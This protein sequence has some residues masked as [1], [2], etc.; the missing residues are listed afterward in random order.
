MS[1]KTGKMLKEL[2]KERGVTL[3]TVADAIG[4]SPSYLHR[5]ENNDRKNPSFT[6]MT[7]LADYYKVDMSELTELSQGQMTDLMT[8][9]EIHEEINRAVAQMKEGLDLHKRND[10]H[11]IQKFIE[12]Q[13]SLLYVQSLI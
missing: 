12:V 8:S 4:C 5:L 10:K 11:S 7:K 6:T 3:Q 9:T 1:T 13:K 2:R